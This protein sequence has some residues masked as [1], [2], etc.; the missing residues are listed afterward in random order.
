[1]VALELSSTNPLPI[2]QIGEATYTATTNVTPNATGLYALL[3][4][5]TGKVV[6]VTRVRFSGSMTTHATGNIALVRY[7][8]VTGGTLVGA[9][10]GSLDSANAAA[11]A[12]VA[13]SRSRC[14][15]VTVRG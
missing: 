3:Q 9:N 12:A 6:R 15:Y 5:A 1:M 7:T 11:S 4:G 13:P 8:S 14:R 2:R 10:P